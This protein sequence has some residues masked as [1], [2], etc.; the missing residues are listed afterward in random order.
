[1][2]RIFNKNRVKNSGIKIP[3]GPWDSEPDMVEWEFKNSICAIVRNSLES[4]CGYAGVYQGHPSYEKG[5]DEV[6]CQAHGGLTFSS[7]QYSDREHH[8]KNG[9]KVWYFGFDCA[10]SGDCIPGMS[11]LLTSGVKAFEDPIRG[12]YRNIGYV[13]AET[14]QLASQLMMQECDCGHLYQ[15]HPFGICSHDCKCS[16]L[17]KTREI[18]EA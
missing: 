2:L 18:I 6:E 7:Y 10:H 17:I 8:L 16:D 3:P 9:N 14:E 15:D 13:L 4:L 1:M 11:G 5:Y 12:T